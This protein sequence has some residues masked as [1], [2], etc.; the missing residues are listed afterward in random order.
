M[1]TATA[2]TRLSPENPALRP[3]D[4]HRSMSPAACAEGAKATLAAAARA[5]TE[6]RSFMSVH[7]QVEACPAAADLH[8]LAERAGATAQP[9]PERV[10]GGPHRHEVGLRV[11]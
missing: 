3:L 7:R 9:L 2:V 11:S 4:T 10:V 5:S 6:D 8:G 1:P